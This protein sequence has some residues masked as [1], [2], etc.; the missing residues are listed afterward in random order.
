MLRDGQGRISQA[1]WMITVPGVLL[2]ATVLA[3]NLIGDALRDA[4]DPRARQR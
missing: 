4:L 1:W 2:F 3:L